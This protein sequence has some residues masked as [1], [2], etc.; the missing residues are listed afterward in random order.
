MNNT[1][2]PNR[3]FFSIAAWYAVVA[4]FVVIAVW[5]VCGVLDRLS[6]GCNK[7]YVFETVIFVSG[8]G[9]ITSVAASIV[10]LFGIRR[11]G[12]RFIVTKS[13]GGFV[14]SYL[15]FVQ[16]FVAI[17]R[18]LEV[19]RQCMASHQVTGQMG[20]LQFNWPVVLWES[21]VGLCKTSVPLTVIVLVV[22]G[23]L[24]RLFPRPFNNKDKEE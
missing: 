1:P 9:P 24:H 13:L 22:W 17:E 12:W 3:S 20:Q 19:S 6:V 15:I 14:L 2:N 23:V 21:L 18:I 11:H 10:S 8:F 4:P 16:I 7:E 5:G